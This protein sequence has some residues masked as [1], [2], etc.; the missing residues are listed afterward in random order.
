MVQARSMDPASTVL[1][2]SGGAFFLVGLLS[3]VWKYACIRQ[4]PDAQAPVYV[5]ITH[6]AA[7]MYAFC[8]VVIQRFV[9]ASALSSEVEL[10]A[11]VAQVLFFSL[12]ISTYLIHGLLR[13]TDNQLAR[14]HRL[15]RRQLPGFLVHGFMLSLIAGEIGGF[16][17]LMYGAAVATGS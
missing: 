6:R 14:P 10:F 1:L 9:D 7:L 16:V 17:V 2:W 5:D 11:V 15:G 12:A 13:D 8:T 3:G 4:S